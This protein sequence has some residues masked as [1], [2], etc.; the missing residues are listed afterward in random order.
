[1]K[2]SAL[3]LWRVNLSKPT[4]CMMHQQFNIQQL[5]ALPTLYL[6]VL[7]LSGNTATWATYSINWL[8]FITEMKSVY[9]AVRTGSLNEAVCASA[10][11]GQNCVC[12][13]LETLR[14]LPYF[15][16]RRRIYFSLQNF[17]KIPLPLNIVRND[18]LLIM[19]RVL[20]NSSGEYGMYFVLSSYPCFALYWKLGPKEVIMLSHK[21]WELYITDCLSRASDFH[22][23]QRYCH[24][25]KKTRKC[26]AEMLIREGGWS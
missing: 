16:H 1:M 7:Y 13:P 12:Y 8:V 10:L 26:S 5:Y 20:F 9:S 24:W 19:E 21:V 18:R 15:Y 2:R 22:C 14:K 3:R 6:C 17:P 23:L 25:W 4:C 11:K